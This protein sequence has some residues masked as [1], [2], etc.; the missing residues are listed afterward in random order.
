MGMSVLAGP[1]AAACEKRIIRKLGIGKRTL[2]V[3]AI[4]G[5]SD[6][7]LFFALRLKDSLEL[8]GVPAQNTRITL[9]GAEDIIASLLQVSKEQYGFGY[10]NVYDAS[11][12]TARALIRLCPPWESVSFGPDGKAKEDYECVIVGF[13]SHGQAVL[14][15]LVM[16]AQFEG[17]RFRAAVFSPA[18]SKEAGYF[19]ADCPELLSR[20]QIKSVE[21]DARSGEFYS[22]LQQRLPSLKLI[23]VC[24]GDEKSNR[25]ISD[26]MMLFLQRRGAERI[27]VVRCGD[28]GVQYQKQVG[29]P[30]RTMDIYTKAFLSAE[31]ADQNAIVLNAAY[32]TSEK[33]DWEKWVACT[34]FSKM[35]SRASAEF[36]PAFVRAS[37][38]SRAEIMSG[39]W[40]PAKDVLEN[41]GKTEHLRW[42]AFHFAN[43]YRT[44]T[45]DEFNA[46]AA[47]WRRCR[48][49]GVPCKVRISKDAA[50]RTHA[51]LIP[52]DDLDALS[53]KE[54]AVTG[55]NV[56]YK[57]YDINNVLALPRLLRA[58]EE[59]AK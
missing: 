45:D 33:S 53:E 27:R 1:S 52:W 47:E 11:D 50:A 8:L 46:N 29:S 12:L 3:Y 48:E 10:V 38:S 16:N 43:G 28:T 44:M 25:E 19:K 51:C 40:H 5:D 15:Q 24:T 23:A 31:D 58:G 54:N 39:N 56:D 55:G 59:D 41:L 26:S 37:G 9:P 20:Y 14:K 35:S 2:S 30:I 4:D 57:Q 18:F 7:D 13:G 21:A 17:S 34:S 49:E 6:K 22:F 42:N 36:L 32:D